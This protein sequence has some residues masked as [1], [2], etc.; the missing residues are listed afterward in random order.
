MILPTILSMTSSPDGH[1]V[2]THRFQALIFNILFGII[3]VT[4]FFKHNFQFTEFNQY[5]LA[6][7][8]LSSGGYLAIENK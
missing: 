1:G 6:T 5:E 7:L 4:F 2:C 3:F 8:G